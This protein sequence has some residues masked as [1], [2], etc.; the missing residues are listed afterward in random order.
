M[1]GDTP[2]TEEV[3]GAVKEIGKEE[4]EEEER[5]RE[6]EGEETVGEAGEEAAVEIEEGD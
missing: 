2:G 1:K 3:V 6:R 4:V 5:E